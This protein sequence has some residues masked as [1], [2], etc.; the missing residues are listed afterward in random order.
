MAC[1]RKRTGSHDLK[2]KASAEKTT[3][4]R[5]TLILTTRYHSLKPKVGEFYYKAWGVSRNV[6]VMQWI[7]KSDGGWTK[8]RFRAFAGA[9]KAAG[10]K[11]SRFFGDQGWPALQGV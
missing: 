2:G 4:P 3:T 10:L 8:E 11:G 6:V 7:K 5:A 1:A 9:D